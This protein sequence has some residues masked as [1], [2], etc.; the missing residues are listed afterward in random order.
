MSAPKVKN[1][2]TVPPCLTRLSPAPPIHKNPV[3]NVSFYTCDATG[4]PTETRVGLPAAFVRAKPE[5]DDP[6][7]YGAFKDWNTAAAYVRHCQQKG[8]ICGP[9]ADEICAWIRTQALAWNPQFSETMY[10]LPGPL[11]VLKLHGGTTSH[12]EWSRSYTAFPGGCIEPEFD[13]QRRAE[14]KQRKVTPTPSK[15]RISLADEVFLRA[16]P[17]AVHR[18]DVYVMPDLG[19]AATR[20]VGIQAGDAMVTELA[21]AAAVP[22][23]PY[24]PDS[25]PWTYSAPIKWSRAQETFRKT[26]LGSALPEAAK[27]KRKVAT[28]AKQVAAREKKMA[29]VR[30]QYDSAASELKELRKKAAGL[31]SA[32]P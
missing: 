24:A 18:L 3:S 29:E 32:K 17:G 7:S 13:E 14:Q 11:S 19:L 28:A 22:E 6:R 25:A 31:V 16:P 15:R 10:K 21:K 26:L 9:R 12:E 30:A 23:L 8:L 20:N 5:P 1:A 4:E 27:Q 2:K